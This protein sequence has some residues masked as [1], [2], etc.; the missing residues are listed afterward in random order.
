MN[1]KSIVAGLGKDELALRYRS[2]SAQPLADH[3]SVSDFVA[4]TKPACDDAC[5]LHRARCNEL[6]S[7]PT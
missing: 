6:R 4:L 1:V 7:R 2:D 5:R 3:W